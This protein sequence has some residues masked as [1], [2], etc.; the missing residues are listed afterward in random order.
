MAMNFAPMDCSWQGA[1]SEPEKNYRDFSVL[2]KLA[3]NQK[4]HIFVSHSKK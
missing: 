1:S 3:I 2:A 4:I